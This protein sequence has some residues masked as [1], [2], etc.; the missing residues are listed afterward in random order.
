MENIVTLKSRLGFIHSANN[1]GLHMYKICTLL[2]STGIKIFCAANNMGLPSFNS[3][4]RALEKA[5]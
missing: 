3:T 4:Q 5:I 2:K 1:I